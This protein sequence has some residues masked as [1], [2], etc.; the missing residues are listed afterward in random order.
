MW[1]TITVKATSECFQNNFKVGFWAHP[2]GY[3][4]FN[5]GI[6]YAQQRFAKQQRMARMLLTKHVP[7]KLQFSSQQE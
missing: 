6:T 2:L 1:S 7:A 4:G 5:L 3:K